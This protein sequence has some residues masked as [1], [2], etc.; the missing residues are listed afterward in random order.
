VERRASDIGWKVGN[1]W[2]GKAVISKEKRENK[3]KEN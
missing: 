3:L 2:N 1:W